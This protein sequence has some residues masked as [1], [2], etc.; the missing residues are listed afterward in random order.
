MVTRRSG[1]GV[2][3]NKKGL[4]RAYA[5]SPAEVST[6]FNTNYSVGCQ[7]VQRQYEANVT[8][9]QISMKAKMPF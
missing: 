3:L 9:R 2:T 4:K 5:R 8:G 1:F 7:Q 6:S